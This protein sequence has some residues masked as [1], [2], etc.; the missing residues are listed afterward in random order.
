MCGSRRLTSD[1]CVAIIEGRA[2][3][4]G[5]AVAVGAAIALALLNE[6]VRDE[7][8]EILVQAAVVDL[9][10]V[11]GGEIRFEREPALFVGLGER[12]QEVSLERSEIRERVL[13]FGTV[14]VHAAP[15][16]QARLTGAYS[17][18]SKP[19]AGAE[20]HVQPSLLILS[21][22]LVVAQG[23]SPAVVIVRMV[24]WGLAQNPTRLGA[25]TPQLGFLH[26]IASRGFVARAL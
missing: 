13:G 24:L 16:A 12:P 19:S 18:A 9:I 2:C 1:P 21:D 25:P 11:V 14:F 15:P 7:F 3:R 6:L 17:C 4:V 22:S 23:L 10:L 8:V 20:Q 5:Q 26:F